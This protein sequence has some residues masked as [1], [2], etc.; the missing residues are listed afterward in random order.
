MIKLP[1]RNQQASFIPAS[2]QNISV[3]RDAFDQGGS[4]LVALAKGIDNLADAADRIASKKRKEDDERNAII[5]ALQ[6]KD[7]ADRE[8]LV[9]PDQTGFLNLQGAEALT[10]YDAVQRGMAETHQAVR[11]TLP[12]ETGK[13]RFDSASLAIAGPLQRMMAAHYEKQRISSFREIADRA[14]D[15][16]RKTLVSFRDDP[17]IAEIAWRSGE[18][19]AARAAN[20]DPDPAM[21]AEDA[22][23][24]W[25]SKTHSAIIAD[26]LEKGQVQDAEAY[27]QANKGQIRDD[28]FQSVSPR[29]SLAMD[30]YRVNQA[31]APLTTAFDG[32]KTRMGRL[33][34]GPLLP[35]LQRS[36][37]RLMVDQGGVQG[38]GRAGTV[39]ESQPAALPPS[40]FAQTQYYGMPPLTAVE[41]E[42]S[43]LSTSHRLTPEQHS[44]GLA[45]VRRAFGKH[46]VQAR[47]YHQ[48]VLSE[49]HRWLE[50]GNTVEG[51]APDMVR[52]LSPRSLNGLK[53]QQDIHDGLRV[54]TTDFATALWLGSLPPASFAQRVTL[55]D[56]PYLSPTANRIVDSLQTSLKS[57][58]FSQ[59]NRARAYLSV[60]NKINQA[61]IIG[62]TSMRD[63][64]LLETLYLHAFRQAE[65][66]LKEY[67]SLTDDQ[68]WDAVSP[69][70]MNRVKSRLKSGG[71]LKPDVD[72]V[73]FHILSAETG[74]P[75]DMVQATWESLITQPDPDLSLEGMFEHYRR[76]PAAIA[77][78]ALGYPYEALRPVVSD[79]LKANV[80]PSLQTIMPEW[81]RQAPLMPSYWF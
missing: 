9:G 62:G 18:A 55:E 44:L 59:Q 19:E 45:S 73:S 4:S 61:A 36:A 64:A 69:V 3:D 78:R 40:P 67:G 70:I 47:E 38:D 65:V 8:A 27:L 22:V 48:E 51:L 81:E 37:D 39:T 46:I 68:A 66:Q 6:Q 17:D 60:M 11:E 50:K 26:Q 14:Q 21:T 42:Y 15:E 16:A 23:A 29:V 49:S 31:I 24:T 72:T 80:L 12:T 32:W 52:S 10:Q 58:D 57:K 53:R 35:S 25:R 5:Q 2:Y 77:A 33:S 20:L 1:S 56:R 54:P 7:A 76:D 41:Q 71:S 43:G 75:A 28:D 13:A 63:P 34:E 30:Q 79:L 74:V